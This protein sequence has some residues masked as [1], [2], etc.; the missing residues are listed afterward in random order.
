MQGFYCKL[1]QRFFCHQ[2]EAEI[3]HCTSLEHYDRLRRHLEPPLR[4]PP[5]GAHGHPH[6]YQDRPG[7]DYRKP[8]YRRNDFIMATLEKFRDLR[9]QAIHEN[10]E[11]RGI[12]NGGDR[13]M[14]SKFFGELILTSR[15]ILF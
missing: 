6:H 2:A 1:C 9:T 11:R 10:L 15:T 14:V 8:H 4:H 5:E 3:D 7:Q 13:Q 12:K